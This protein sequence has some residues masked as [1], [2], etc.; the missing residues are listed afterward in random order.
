MMTDEDILT[1][2][3]DPKTLANYERDQ[4]RIARLKDEL[5]LVLKTVT[6]DGQKAISAMAE[7]ELE[8]RR[9]EEQKKL[10]VKQDE[11]ADKQLELAKTAT[12]WTVRLT[13]ATYGLLAA[14]FVQAIAG[15][16][17]VVVA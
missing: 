2:Y 17:Q 3:V 7:A 8:R 6:A 11:I 15:V 5:V 16:A 13:W 1:T 4:E 10:L 14:S 12:N 9:N